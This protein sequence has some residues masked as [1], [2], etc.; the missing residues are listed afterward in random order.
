[1][2]Q[3]DLS[4]NEVCKIENYRDQVYSALPNL[5]ILDGKDREGESFFSLENEEDYGEEGEFDL[6]N[7]LKM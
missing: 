7:D 4:E 3:L 5:E 6:E 2:M 1:M